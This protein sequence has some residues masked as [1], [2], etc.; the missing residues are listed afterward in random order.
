MKFIQFL[1]EAPRSV[2]YSR[3]EF[4]GIPS[5]STVNDEYELFDESYDLYSKESTHGTKFA[6]L[7][8]DDR[9]VDYFC[10]VDDVGNKSYS[11]KLVFKRE[12]VSSNLVQQI[13]FNFILPEFKRIV[14]D[15]EQTKGG[16]AMWEKII[17]T[18]ISNSKYEVGYISGPKSSKFD[19][20]NWNAEFKYPFLNSAFQF[21]ITRK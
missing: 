21:Y 7:N 17:G 18:A 6:V 15:E 1:N 3:D 16:R 10:V 14:T 2:E 12:G 19:P 5:Y 9:K 11:Q 8:H 20:E 13:F 4:S